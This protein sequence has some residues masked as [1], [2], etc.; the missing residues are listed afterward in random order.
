ME[1]FVV[2]S[3]QII[4]G[5]LLTPYWGNSFIF[6]ALQLFFTMLGLS[7]GYYMIPT[8]LEKIASGSLQKLEKTLLFVFFYLLVTLVFSDG[9]SFYLVSTCSSPLTGMLFSQV[10]FIF[11]PFTLLGSVP[12]QVIL[13]S[14]KQKEASQGQ[15][16]GEVFS[17][18]SLAGIFS[19]FLFAFVALPL[20]GIAFSIAILL[21]G[22]SGVLVFF[23]G[24]E[25]KK[26]LIYLLP[27]LAILG[28]VILVTK[29]KNSKRPNMQAGIRTT[30]MHSGILGQLKVMEIQSTQS[31]Y[32]YLNNALQSKTHLT[33]RSLYPYVYSLVMYSTC[34]PAGS[35][36][37]IAGMGGGSLAFEYDRMGYKV[38]IVDIDGRLPE[39][40]ER[41]FLVPAKKPEFTESDIR[42]YIKR[43]EKK[44]DI[45]VF[46]LSKGE[47]VPTNVYTLECFK[48]VQKR[49]N[50]GGIILIHFLSS[51]S[52]DGEK[53]LCSIKRTL[54]E[55]GFNCELMNHRNKKDLKEGSGPE[56]SEAYIFMA[57]QKIDLSS[58]NFMI[59]SSLLKELL[60]DKKHL[61]LELDGSKGYLL[62]D[63]K[64][65][66]DVLQSQNAFTMRKENIKSLLE[67]SKYVR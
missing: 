61:F 11:I 1:G 62:T 32:L 5:V 12:V 45:I 47:C 30:E 55:A 56:I 19:V 54:L 25:K 57:A 38:D 60:P 42:R 63:D 27:A 31:R 52:G 34:R 10:I 51:L 50:Q 37:L 21:V 24:R 65:I 6:W 46:D 15:R 8:W 9:I 22:V 66:L 28:S 36:V 35:S 7:A 44:Y 53:A 67:V 41:N 23:L 48:E 16:T 29:E 49:L 3:L 40:V 26:K 43:T 20:A 18:S 58:S 17:A 2:L 64:P 59:D 39:V 14:E 33:G 13:L 4:G